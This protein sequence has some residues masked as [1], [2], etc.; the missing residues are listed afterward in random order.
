[1]VIPEA[2]EGTVVKEKEEEGH[3]KYKAQIR[4]SIGVGAQGRGGRH[5]TWQGTGGKDRV[6]SLQRT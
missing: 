6:V 1:M 5:H 3:Y 2:W 4:A